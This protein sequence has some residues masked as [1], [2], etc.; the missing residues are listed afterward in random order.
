VVDGEMKWER[1]K[2]AGIK[3]LVCNSHESRRVEETSEGGQDFM[4]CSADDDEYY[5]YSI[6]TY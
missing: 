2:D 4:S 6:V 1:T 3:E 5:V